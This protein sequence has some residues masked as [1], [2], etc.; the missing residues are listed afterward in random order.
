MKKICNVLCTFFLYVSSLQL[1][2]LWFHADVCKK[3]VEQLEER[4]TKSKHFNI[5]KVSSSIIV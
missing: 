2:A 3:G 1:L 4:L 5:L